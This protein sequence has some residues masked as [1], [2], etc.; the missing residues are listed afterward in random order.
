MRCFQEWR[1]A[2]CVCVM[3][4]Y[5]MTEVLPLAVT[6]MLPVILFPLTGVLSSKDVAEQFINVSVSDSS[7]QTGSSKEVSWSLVFA[8]QKI[9]LAMVVLVLCW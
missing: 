5:W 7:Q 9:H 1:C 2:F 4:A 3:A 8:G 6:A